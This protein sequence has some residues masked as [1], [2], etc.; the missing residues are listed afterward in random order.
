MN[1]KSSTPTRTPTAE[2]ARPSAPRMGLPPRR[3]KSSPRSP[4]P[5]ERAQASKKKPRRK[6]PGTPP[7]KSKT[8]A[9]RPGSRCPA[10]RAAGAGCRKATMPAAR[11]KRSRECFSEPDPASS[12][13]GCLA[14]APPFSNHHEMLRVNDWPNGL[15]EH[16]VAE[17]RDGREHFL[18]ADR[19]F[20]GKI[21][22]THQLR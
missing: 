15:F 6:Q 5:P 3:C 7:R 1:A 14:A 20:V 2:Q 11:T 17:W 16:N 22:N 8:A 9:A 4:P 13:S 18:A 21:P 12:G 10:E 19:P